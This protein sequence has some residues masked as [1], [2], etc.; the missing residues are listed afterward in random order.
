MVYPGN[1]FEGYFWIEEPL[2]L[3]YTAYPKG[4]PFTNQDYLSLEV[5]LSVPLAHDHF[6][7]VDGDQ[8]PNGVTLYNWNE[9]PSHPDHWSPP[10]IPP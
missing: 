9:L 6:W 3:A 2:R 1:N 5:P 7:V 4:G 10:S 8:T